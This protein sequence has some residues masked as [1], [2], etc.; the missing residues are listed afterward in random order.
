MTKPPSHYL[1]DHVR[2]TTQPLE[3]PERDGDLLDVLSMF[4]YDRLLM[5]S[6]DYP[7]EFFAAPGALGFI[8]EAAR[9]RTWWENARRRLV[10]E[11]EAA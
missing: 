2:F 10:P 5:Y 1:R 6:S 11:R 9:Q 4:E 7:D 8:P 3:R